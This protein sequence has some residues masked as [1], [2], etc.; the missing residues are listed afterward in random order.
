MNLRNTLSRKLHSF[1]SKLLLAFLVAVFIP[2]IAITGISWYVSRGIATDNI[3]T[4]VLMN[5]EQLTAQINNRISQTESIA[6]TVNYRMYNLESASSDVMNAINTFVSLRN[7]LS[8]YKNIFNLYHIFVFLNESQDAISMGINEGLYFFPLDKLKECGI[9]TAQLTAAGTNSCWI[10]SDGLSL[11]YV[12]NGKNTDSTIL[13]FR[14]LTN[15][16]THILEY[17]YCIALKPSDFSDMLSASISAE[18]ISSYILS[19]DG[20]IIASGNPEENG[21]MLSQENI[22]LFL[23]GSNT[24]YHQNHTYYNNVTLSNGWIHITEI[25]DEYLQRNTHILVRSILVAFFLC[26]SLSIFIIVFFSENLS[27]RLKKLSSAMESFHL[28]HN[29]APSGAI[30]LSYPEK[31]E[32]YDEIDKL[33]I[34]F[35]EMQ[36]TD[37]K[38]VV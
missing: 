9:D 7:D 30:S 10:S 15:Q 19:P 21:T 16:S 3:L 34:S 5:D 25:P 37:R 27:R 24:L 6:D 20:R 23:A 2:L 12:L 38:S 1:R 13:C 33:G 11:P 26:I 32:H 35:E 28:E 8:L 4:S 31:E 36:H 29:S 17:A 18:E 14:T 22:E